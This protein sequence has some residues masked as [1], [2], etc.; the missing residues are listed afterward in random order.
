MRVKANIFSCA[1]GVNFLENFVS[2]LY[3]GEILPQL[4][5][6]DLSRLEILV[7]TKRAA[8][9]LKQCFLQYAQRA[10]ILPQIN[11]FSEID[12]LASYG[13]LDDAARQQA[14]QPIINAT[15]R[16]LLLAQLVQQ[17]QQASLYPGL[18]AANPIW[19]AHELAQLIDEAALYAIDWQELEKLGQDLAANLSEWWLLS[20]DFLKIVTQYW[21]EI[22]RSKQNLDIGAARWLQFYNKAQLVRQQQTPIIA[23]GSS[24]AVP[25]VA[26][27]LEAIAESKNGAIILPGLDRDLSPQIWESFADYKNNPTLYS[28][29][30][31]HYYHLL[32]RLKIQRSEVKY[33][34][35]AASQLRHRE[36]YIAKA[37]MPASASMEWADLPREHMA[38][39]FADVALVEAHSAQEEATAIAI[40]LRIA[41]QQPEKTAAFVTGDRNLARR[42]SSEL[43]RFGIK[44]NDS[45]QQP[46]LSL[47]QMQ[48]MQLI[49]QSCASND[50]N[51]LL[52]VLK[53]VLA[54]LGYTAAQLRE[55]VELY[56]VYRLRGAVLR[57]SLLELARLEQQMHSQWLDQESGENL[58]YNE[59]IAQKLQQ[60]VSRIDNA[61]APLRNILAAES[62]SLSQACAA[63]LSCFENFGRQN[64]GSIAHLYE[65]TAG[66]GIINFFQEI[67][68][69]GVDYYFAGKDFAQILTALAANVNIEPNPA[70]SN[71][72][73]WG[74]LEARLQYADLL[75]IGGLN[76][77]SLPKIPATSPF[78]SRLMSV[79]L[80][81]A[82]PE[83]AIGATALDLQMLFGAPKLI[84]T[85]SMNVDGEAQVASRWL[86]RLQIIIGP[87][88]SGQL[89]Q[90]GAEYLQLASRLD[91]APPS[92]PIQRPAPKPPLDLRPQ[93][94]SISDIARLQSDPYSIYAKK[95]LR[96]RALQPLVREA[97]YREKGSLYHEIL[98]KF[99][100]GQEDRLNIE[101]LEQ[102]ANQEFAA[103]A[104]PSDTELMW[105]CDF[106]KTT[107]HYMEFEKKRKILHSY[108][109][110]ASHPVAIGQTG[111]TLHGRADRIDIRRESDG[112]LVADI[113]DYKT[114]ELPTSKSIENLENLQLLL[115]AGLLLRGGFGLE[116]KCE[117]GQLIYVRLHRE[118]I[119]DSVIVQTS[120]P[121]EAEPLVEKAWNDAGNLID[122]YQNIEQSYIAYKTIL[123]NREKDW[124]EFYHLSRYEEWAR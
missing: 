35:Q 117:L 11:S 87:D 108:V 60:L 73:I 17:W 50:I 116:H 115:E 2:S 104:L 102:I 31:F 57:F 78:M 99:I 69:S 41:A 61:I 98:A 83:A 39:A 46:L 32:K 75:I 94:F 64:D 10:V 118:D 110:H 37:F 59:E 105:R 91:E 63:L 71:I 58:D 25:S 93:R 56:E 66:R 124:S 101:E 62:I 96:L 76:E 38:Q 7:P 45:G 97:Q 3:Q 84:L 9:S 48:L 53:H 23:L 13:I 27:L 42:V 20:H 44:A 80:G 82:P 52:S 54:R 123:S 33:I 67:A 119:K 111:A 95:I 26:L 81:L 121:G 113:I 49:L 89:L 1:S 68:D 79:R 86:Q 114:G 88:L 120:K 43:A 47:P 100:G 107:M 85:R 65:G 70:Q 30:Q 34:G 29:A 6:Q 74:M 36:F 77:G 51:I 16:I 103:L 12:N 106:E 5:L 28:Q 8:R 4:N 22:L 14:N 90:R 55:L 109:E 72:Y 122:S 112:R 19:L 15:A 18:N 21:P 40:G 92:Q 24:G